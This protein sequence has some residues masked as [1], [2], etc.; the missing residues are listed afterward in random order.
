MMCCHMGGKPGTATGFRPP[1]HHNPPDGGDSGGDSDYE[2][3]GDAAKHS[4]A[5]AERHG[6]SADLI[7][8]KEGEGGEGRRRREIRRGKGGCG[9]K[10]RKV[11]GNK[12]DFKVIHSNCQGFISKQASIEDIIRS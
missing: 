7:K 10:N 5:P 9:R 8:E 12:T 11:Q 6:R 3:G 2:S 1:P 4:A